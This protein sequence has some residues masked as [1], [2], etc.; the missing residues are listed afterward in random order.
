M[1]F[2]LTKNVQRRDADL[3][4]MFL[5]LQVTVLLKECADIKLRF[6]GERFQI[7][8]SLEKPTSLVSGTASD[9]VI[10]DRLV[11]IRFAYLPLYLD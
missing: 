2:L 10:S 5:F 3:Q 9:V 7:Q 1:G 6:G 4:L 8:G 11:R